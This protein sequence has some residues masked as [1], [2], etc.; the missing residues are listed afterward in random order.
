MSEPMAT[1]GE[2][3]R[4][5]DSGYD[6]GYKVGYDVGFNA[7]HDEGYKTGYNR[8]YDD[9][10]KAS[11]EAGY[12]AG[13]DEGYK[14]SYDPGYNDGY[15]A[16]YDA[17]YRKGYDDGFGT[18]WDN[19]FDQGYDSSY[20]VGYHRGFKAGYLDGASEI[21]IVAA[22]EAVTSLLPEN[23]I[24]PTLSV[25]E[26]IRRGLASCQDQLVPLLSGAEVAARIQRALASQAPLSIVRLGDGEALTL[27]QEV[28]LD[29]PT[30]QRRAPW[31]S[32]AGVEVPDPAAR[33]ALKEAV[34]R[35]DIVGVPTSR[36]HNHQ[37]LLF[38]AFAALKIDWTKL[39]LTHAIINY[40]VQKEGLLKE[41]I[42][43]HAVLLVG[44]HAQALR[45]VLEAAGVNVT[46]AISPVNGVRDV[47][48]V[49]EQVRSCDFDIAFVAAG[50]AAVILAQRIASEMG[51]V[52]LDF[53]HL[54]DELIHG[55]ATW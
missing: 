37:P 47:D 7:G 32:R 14:A 4:T 36:I 40:I 53:G 44:N 30:I 20:N 51:K 3:E 45:S 33:D 54:A 39:A 52:A 8:G 21:G 34:L 38:K 17:G 35:A 6:A 2:R 10:Y 46:G 48:R 42:G 29:V 9:G 1:R 43:T 49:M 31:L 25:Q 19:A 23:A 18:S 24:L 5:Y 27:A 26:L 12:K 11:H 13:Y 22:E 16:G 55:Q 15:N 41:A 50:I 28:V